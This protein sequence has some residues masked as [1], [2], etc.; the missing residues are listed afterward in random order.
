MK[1]MDL[2]FFVDNVREDELKISHTEVGS[3]AL[4]TE[5]VGDNLV[6]LM[7]DDLMTSRELR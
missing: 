4:I 7:L 1:K 5:H 6:F 3:E 2:I